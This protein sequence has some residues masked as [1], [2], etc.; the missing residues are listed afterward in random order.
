M[1]N[2]IVLLALLAVV[3]WVGW[4]LWQNGWDWKKAAAAIV[5]AA[6][7][8]WLWVQDSIT[9]LTSGL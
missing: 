6:A 7:A 5:A 1:L 9:S 2:T 3:L 4:T 8:A